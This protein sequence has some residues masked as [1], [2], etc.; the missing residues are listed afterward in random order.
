MC[1]ENIEN[2]TI[3]HKFLELEKTLR[4]SVLQ[5]CTWR[6]HSFC[7]ILQRKPSAAARTH[8]VTRHC[9]LGWGI[10]VRKYTSFMCNSNY[11]K[12]WLLITSPIQ[13]HCCLQPQYHTQPTHPPH[14]PCFFKCYNLSLLQCR[15]CTCSVPPSFP[16]HLINCLAIDS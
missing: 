1:E 16:Q 7:E 14:L 4:D 9:S 15:D 11:L 6:K 10:R 12:I 2:L 3:A 5:S 13:S 8:A